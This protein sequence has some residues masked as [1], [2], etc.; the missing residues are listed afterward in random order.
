MPYVNINITKAFSCHL[1]DSALS[2]YLSST[3]ALEP[4][5]IDRL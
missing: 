5:V 1:E 2:T 4:K 3:A